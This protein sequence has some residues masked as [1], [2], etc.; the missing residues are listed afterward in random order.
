M[1][2]VVLGAKCTAGDNQTKSPAQIKLIIIMTI[3]I[4]SVPG[5]VPYSIPVTHFILTYC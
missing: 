1:L 2:G 3:A 4:Y 5:T